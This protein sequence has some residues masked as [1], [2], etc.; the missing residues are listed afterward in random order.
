ML[1]PI[2][3]EYN[4]YVKVGEIDMNMLIVEHSKKE[5]EKLHYLLLS[6][7][8]HSFSAQNMK[9]A[10]SIL[11]KKD[12]SA[13]IIDVDNNDVEGLQL[14]KD[15]Q[16]DEKL[17]KIP[18][19]VHSVRSN[20]EFVME[21]ID[22]GCIGY[23]LKSL[24][25]ETALEKLKQ[26]LTK[27]DNHDTQRKHIRIQ[28]DPEEL[29]RLNFRI[30]GYS[31]L[32]SGKILDLSMGGVATELFNPPPYNVLK[33]GVKIPL[34]QFNLLAVQIEAEGIVVARKEKI[35]AIK[36]TSMSV[37]NKSNLARYIY[38]KIS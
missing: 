16:Q 7:G 35:I 33:K 36:F 11:S 27:L 20:K 23:L 28:P 8:V 5:I 18:F 1:T 2:K 38:K 26:I 19:I 29:L 34:I 22:L 6:L 25:D 9:D 37:D 24:P 3:L 12:I 10:L 30:P 17:K 15:I 31:R 4:L 32:I 14:I 13:I 21:M